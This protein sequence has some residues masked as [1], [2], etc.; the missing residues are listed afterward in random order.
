M[1]KLFELVSQYDPAKGGLPCIYAGP[2]GRAIPT[3]WRAAGWRRGNVAAYFSKIVLKVPGPESTMERQ[4]YQLC[5]GLKAE[6]DGAFHG[7]QSL[8]DE[9]LTT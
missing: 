7:V 6:I 1:W 3:A 2:P 4:Y 9:K 8:W 5:V